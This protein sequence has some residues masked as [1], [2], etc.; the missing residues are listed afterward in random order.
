M[1]QPA[2]K[3]H[4][5]FAAESSYA[6]VMSKGDDN[7]EIRARITRRLEELG[8]SKR[9]VSLAIGQGQSYLHDFLRKFVPLRLPEDV[10]ARLAEELLMDENDLGG[11]RPARVAGKLPAKIDSL[12]VAK[13]M[14]LTL[15][16]LAGDD[17]ARRKVVEIGEQAEIITLMINAAAGRA[18]DTK[19]ANHL[20]LSVRSALSDML[21]SRDAPI[22]DRLALEAAAA[23]LPDFLRALNT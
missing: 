17:F 13:W 16:S 4:F 15:A 18:T 2:E 21:E 1:T 19:R 6:A 20:A 23:L 3:S 10:R 11:R 9:A 8:K 7:E 14:T 12:T 5:R 22:V